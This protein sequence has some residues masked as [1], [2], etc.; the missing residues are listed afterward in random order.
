MLSLAQIALNAVTLLRALNV[1]DP[2]CIA[3]NSARQVSDC[4]PEIDAG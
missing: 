3:A 2:H 4:V 1:R